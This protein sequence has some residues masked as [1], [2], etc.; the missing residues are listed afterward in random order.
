[1]KNKDLDLKSLG[2]QALIA[3]RK[4]NRYAGI[5]FLLLV[6]AVYGFVLF[7]IDTLSNVQP[8]SDDVSAMSKSTSIPKID[9]K[10]V[11]QLEALKDNSENVQTL[12]K[13]ARGNPFQE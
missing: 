11:M 12:F 5:L 13:Q 6:A 8:N 10:V 4:L 9:P 2:P 1:M 7:R 3:L